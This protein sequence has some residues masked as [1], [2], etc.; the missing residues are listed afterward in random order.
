MEVGS[1]LFFVVIGL[2][3]IVLVVFFI[4]VLIMLWILVLVVGVCISI[5][6]LVGMRFCWVILFCVVNLLIKVSK[7]G[8]G[9]I[10]N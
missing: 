6:I 7:V 10:I 3:I 5:F 9:I 1:V 8:L 4:F 2:V